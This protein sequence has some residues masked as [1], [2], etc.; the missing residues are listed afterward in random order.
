MIESRVSSARPKEVLVDVAR[1]FNSLIVLIGLG[2]GLG[3]WGRS[4]R[5][6]AES[7]LEI[8]IDDGNGVEGPF[9][10]ARRICNKM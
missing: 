10:G 3:H 9:V 8:Q 7:L 6:F 1:D 4:G 5:C 2:I